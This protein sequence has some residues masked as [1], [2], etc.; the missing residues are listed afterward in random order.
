VF[1]FC[2]GR[3]ALVSAPH[4]QAAEAAEHGAFVFAA[5]ARVRHHADVQVDRKTC[6]VASRT[7]RMVRMKITVRDLLWLTTVLAMGVALWRAR[8]S[9]RRWRSDM[10]HREEV[11]SILQEE[12]ES[13]GVKIEVEFDDHGFTVQGMK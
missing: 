7:I 11:I 2:Q 5:A 12:L 3:G 10:Q 4:H 13:E 6:G 1:T 8:V 9:E